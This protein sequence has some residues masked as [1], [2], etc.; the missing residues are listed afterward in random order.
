MIYKYLINYISLII[1]IRELN[2]ESLNNP[3][4]NIPVKVFFCDIF[5]YYTY[6]N[7]KSKCYIF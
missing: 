4:E 2:I 1:E 3:K 7:F 6:F 5:Y